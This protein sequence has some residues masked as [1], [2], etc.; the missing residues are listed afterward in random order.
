M[1]ALHL[2]MICQCSEG[3]ICLFCK[4]LTVIAIAVLSG[5]AGYLIGRKKS[6]K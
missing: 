5:I 4:I 6:E 3:N 2:M 1:N